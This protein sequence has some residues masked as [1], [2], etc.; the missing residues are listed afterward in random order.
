MNEKRKINLFL[1][2]FGMIIIIFS[3]YINTSHSMYG[4]ILT[5]IGIVSITVTLPEWK[6]LKWIKIIILLPGDI[7][8]IIGPLFKIS[9]VFFYAYLMPLIVFAFFYKYVPIYFFNIDL[10]YASN[11]YLTLTSTFIFITIFSEN[12]MV[13]F[14]RIVNN[15]NPGELINLYDN[16][17]THLINKQRTRYLIF[18]GFFLY[19]II[20]SIASL[21]EIELFNIKNTNVAIMQTFGTYIAFDRLISNRT[22]FDFKP[23]TFLHKIAKIWVFDFNPDKDENKNN[24]ENIQ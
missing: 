4:Y 16:L 10:T 9:F 7:L 6:F 8:S 23:K 14:N 21:N 11:V 5:Y 18:F 17:G 22:L 2:V 12:L 1:I 24:N 15:D 20:Y 3:L 13:W 19:L